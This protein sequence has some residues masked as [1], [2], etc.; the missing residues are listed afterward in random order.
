M[1][2]TTRKWLVGAIGWSIALAM[3]TLVA[4]IVPHTI[5]NSDGSGTSVYETAMRAFG[6]LV[7]LFML[8]PLVISV[9]VFRLLQHRATDG[10]GKK[11]IARILTF[12]LAGFA[13]LCMLA[14]FVTPALYVA[15]GFG[16]TA[17]LLISALA[18]DSDSARVTAEHSPQPV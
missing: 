1:G 2:S 15:V 9:V 10:R 7:L 4:P 12:G 18:S 14:A 13:G 6:P 5:T 11:N 17:V 8:V 16:F 3:A